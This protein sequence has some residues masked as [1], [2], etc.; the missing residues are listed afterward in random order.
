MQSGL[1]KTVVCRKSDVA[2]RIVYWQIA[3]E[4][5]MLYNNDQNLRDLDAFCRREED[6]GSR[7]CWWEDSSSQLSGTIIFLRGERL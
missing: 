3:E 4:I 6:S 2:C 1:S 5:E 7:F